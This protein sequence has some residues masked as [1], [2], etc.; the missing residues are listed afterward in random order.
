MTIDTAYLPGL[1][2]H[3]DRARVYQVRRDVHTFHD[4]ACG[5]DVPPSRRTTDWRKV[6]CRRCRRTL[7]YRKAK[8]RT[9]NLSTNPPTHT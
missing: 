1:A 3:L 6:D 5:A 4:A 9:P 8:Q 2:T 7:A